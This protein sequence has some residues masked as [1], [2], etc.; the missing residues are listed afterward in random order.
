MTVA[1]SIWIQR[2]VSAGPA[3]QNMGVHAVARAL[4]QPYVFPFELASVVLL[5]VLVGAVVIA[6]EDTGDGA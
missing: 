2:A 5:A 4:L 1:N 6:K 3:A